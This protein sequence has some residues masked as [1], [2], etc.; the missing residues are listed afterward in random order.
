MECGNGKNGTGIVA[1]EEQQGKTALEGGTVPK[2]RGQNMDTWESARLERLRQ[3]PSPLEFVGKARRELGAIAHGA[4]DGAKGGKKK[5]TPERSGG[6]RAWGGASATPGGKHGKQRLWE[7][8][9]LSLRASPHR[10]WGAA[11]DDGDGAGGASWEPLQGLHEPGQHRSTDYRLP[12][13]H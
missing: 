7:R 13:R 6:G 10:G 11:G 12:T 9:G 5:D 8:G 1:V 2:V 4:G 3:M